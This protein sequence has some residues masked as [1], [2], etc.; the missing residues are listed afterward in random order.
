[1]AVTTEILSGDHEMRMANVLEGTVDDGLEFSRVLYFAAFGEDE[2]GV[3]GFEPGG[4][5]TVFVRLAGLTHFHEESFHNVFLH[6]A[7]LPK[8]ALGM[9]VN[10][11]VA[12][13]DDSH[14]SG[15]FARFA[16]GRLTV[17]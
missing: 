6:T 2:A 11:K 16:F 10:V 5:A 13:L 1:M 9:D 8:N 12:R 7:R 17:R 4:I 3:V 15:F 14:R